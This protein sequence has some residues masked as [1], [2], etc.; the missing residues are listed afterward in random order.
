MLILFSKEK[1]PPLLYIYIH[2][3]TQVPHSQCAHS[4]ILLFEQNYN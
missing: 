3:K 4:L 1:V 2:D